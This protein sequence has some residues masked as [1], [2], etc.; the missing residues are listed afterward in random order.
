MRADQKRKALANFR[1]RRLIACQAA[2]DLLSVIE[3]L[4]VEDGSELP[5]PRGAF[6]PAPSAAHKREM[7]NAATALLRQILVWNDGQ[8]SDAKLLPF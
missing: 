2:A 8:I 5:V 6:C 4:G 7:A 3:A 1:G